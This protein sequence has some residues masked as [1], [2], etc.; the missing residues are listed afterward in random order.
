MK[1]MVKKISIVLCICFFINIAFGSFDSYAAKSKKMKFSKTSVSVVSGKTVNVKIKG[2]YKK[3][4]VVSSKK[5]FVKTKV[6]GKKITIKGV[7]AGKITLTVRGYNKSGKLVAS[8]RIKV[9]V[10]KKTKKTTTEDT[11]SPTNPTDDE[12]A[13]SASTANYDAGEYSINKVHSGEATYYDLNGGGNANLDDFSST[14]LTAAMNKED[15]LNG[16][17]GAYVEVTDKDGD[18][19]KVLIT[20]QLPEGKKG[21][22]DLT[23]AAFKKIEPEI[24]GRMKITWKIIPLPTKQPVSF[25]WKPTSSQWWA[26]I[27][28]RNGRYPIKSV[29]YLDKVTGKYIKLD[30]KPYNYFAATN[31]M[32]GTGPFTFRVTDFYGHTIVEKNIPLS[33]SGVPIKGKSNFPY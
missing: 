6:K 23:R 3:I 28:V 21:D 19:V 10:K 14:Y 12:K 16:L 8:G 17:A 33:T 5:G 18:K 22:I 15:Y 29:E 11:E 2:T 32:G 1:N 4:K 25:L 30:R 9:T 7:K 31:G 20:D 24:T 26:E 13:P 27:Q